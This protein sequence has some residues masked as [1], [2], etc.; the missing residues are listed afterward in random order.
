MWFI[1]DPIT[2][3][4][5]STGRLCCMCEIVTKINIMELHIK[6][7]RRNENYRIATLK[8]DDSQLPIGKIK[9][10]EVH[11]PFLNLKW[12]VFYKNTR[13]NRK[14]NRKTLIFVQQYYANI[15]KAAF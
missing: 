15:L 6:R 2:L 10:G 7:Q 8:K 1:D 13:M 11:L 14:P 12:L 3:P 4:K 5:R 9:D